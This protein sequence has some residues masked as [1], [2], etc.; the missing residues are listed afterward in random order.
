MKVSLFRGF[1][2]RTFCEIM[3][4]EYKH[5][6]TKQIMSTQH[7]FMCVLKTVGKLVL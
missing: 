6:V 5:K 7:S 2:Q 4:S 3:L 1:L